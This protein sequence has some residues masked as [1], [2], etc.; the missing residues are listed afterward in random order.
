M[1]LHAGRHLRL[2]AAIGAVTLAVTGVAGGAAQARP[3]QRPAPAAE[4]PAA[5]IPGVVRVDQIGY[6][7]HD[8]KR[9]FLL[10]RGDATG[11]PFA[12]VDATG[13][14]VL[15]GRVGA[16]RGPWNARYPGVHA[17]NLSAVRRT[18]LYRITVTGKATATSPAFRIGSGEA[19]FG[20]VVNDNVRFFQVQRDGADVIPGRLNRQPS[21]LADRS[22]DVYAA[23]VFTG[24][25]G[26]QIAAPL[27]KIDGPVD[28]EGG[29][30]DAGD[31]VKFTHA[32]AYS[33]AEMLYLERGLERDNR[34]LRAENRFGLKWL[35]KMWDADRKILYMQV[36][37]GTGSEEFGFAGD[38]DVWRLP[39]ADDK[40][41]VQPGDE[42]YFIKH[43]PVFRANNP[44]ERI[45]PNLA[46]RVAAA[47]ALGAQ[48]EAKRNPKKARRLY[49]E[50]ASI[51]ALAKTTNP[52]E[53]VT[54]HPHA[55]YPEDS[56]LDDMEFGATELSR[57][58]YALGKR[59]AGRRYLR[60]ATHWAK[61]YINS[62]AE[63][64][65][66]LYDTSAIAHSDLIGQLR[67][68]RRVSGLQVREKHLLADLRRQL[69]SGR[70]MARTD[71]FRS[72]IDETQFDAATRTFG[73]TATARLYERLTGSQAFDAFGVQ[74]R[75]W[76]LG[77][78]AWGVSLVVGEGSN[79]AHCPQHQVANLAGSVHGGDKV[80]V[81][82]VINGPNGAANFEGIGNDFFEEGQK[83]P[84]DGQDRFAEFNT[85][86]SRFY[87]N[88]ASWP[89]SEPAIDFTSTAMVAF[90]L[91]SRT[92]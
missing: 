30:F 29:W 84:A 86:E 20:N 37:I 83:C 40:L 46:G 92:N 64:T 12:V 33:L 9:A 24:D 36:G 63:D 71:P 11:A 43:R 41:D 81:G 21:H 91:A 14:T 49:A 32:T 90:A 39:E 47:F 85:P 48:V 25:G 69:E 66:N 7:R 5:P 88:V 3:A 89:S 18:G 73:F 22:A 77:A 75:N 4:A 44:G 74:Q 78:N 15:T 52:G 23:P 27:E 68:H 10:A 59:S 28:V 42:L 55:Y 62:D 87:D 31:F 1:K 56:W 6:A 17:I 79:F 82:A 19:L 8:V 76:A 16:N 57:A 38:H 53:L 67:R 50:A 65:L 72:A 58:A 45:S 80:I 26:D 60:A 13:R 70:A 51:F 34:L 2:A 35:D 54:A 61:E